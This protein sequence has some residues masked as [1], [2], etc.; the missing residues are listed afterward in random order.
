[1]KKKRLAETA[2]EFDKRFDAGEDVTDLID[3][4]KTSITRPNRK[5]RIT[6]DIAES[7][8][9]DIDVIREKI[10]VDRGALIKVWLH[11]KV[12]KEKLSSDV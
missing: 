2:E 11:E 3:L 10:G 7:L 9:R 1:M 6:L 12:M 4:S 8:V 5:V